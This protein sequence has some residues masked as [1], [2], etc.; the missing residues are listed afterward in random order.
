MW[1]MFDVSLA[2]VLDMENIGYLDYLGV[3]FH[4]V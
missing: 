4:E 3:Q 2:E 1:S